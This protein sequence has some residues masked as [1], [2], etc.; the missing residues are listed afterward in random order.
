MSLLVKRIKDKILALELER[1]KLVKDIECLQPI[2]KENKNLLQKI[3]NH[4]K[5]LKEKDEIINNFNIQVGELRKEIIT[6]EEM[7]NDDNN[8]LNTENDE[9]KRQLEEVKRELKYKDES[10]NDTITQ[11]ENSISEKSDIERKIEDMKKE[12]KDI[13]NKMTLKDIQLE[14]LKQNEPVRVAKI[15]PVKEEKSTLLID[16]DVAKKTTIQINQPRR[17]SNLYYSMGAGF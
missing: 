5:V 17:R 8:K 3:G 1:D 4:S 2:I 7:D 10:L 16:D 14:R 15:T 9:L 6:L 12:I 11:L 13:T